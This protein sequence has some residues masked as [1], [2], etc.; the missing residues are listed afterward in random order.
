M[1]DVLANRADAK[2]L[3]RVVGVVMVVTSVVILIVNYIV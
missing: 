3:N 1:S 2:T